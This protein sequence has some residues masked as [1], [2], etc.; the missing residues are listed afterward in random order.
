[1]IKIDERLRRL[2]RTFYE[3]G[4]QVYAVGG[5]V[6][7]QLA[8]LPVTDIDIAGTAT[9][10]SLSRI[11]TDTSA[12]GVIERNRALGT[13]E[14]HVYGAPQTLK[15]EYTAFRCDSYR[16]GEHTPTS[17]SFTRD[18]NKDALRRDFTVNAIYADLITGEITDPTAGI[19]DLKLR[20]L[21]TVCPSVFTEDG[22][23]IMRLFR[24]AS[25]LD[26]DIDDATLKSAKANAALLKDISKER[27]FEELRMILTSD[28]KYPLSPRRPLAF[29]LSRMADC[30]VY[31]Y[32]FNGAHVTDASIELCGRVESD[33]ALRFSALL[34]DSDDPRAVMT[35][36][37]APKQLIRDVANTV[38]AFRADLTD[39]VQIK[40]QLISVGKANAQRLIALTENADRSAERLKA[41][42]GFLA[43]CGIL[44]GI[45]GLKVTGDDCIN[46][47]LNG[48]ETGA[49]LEWL[50][51]RVIT[52]ETENDREALLKYLHQK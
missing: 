33:L 6:R 37:K 26:W 41:V 16:G 46:S 40:K 5:Y 23:R 18:I 47:G 9:Y 20:T 29:H 36:L 27:I 12:Y 30:G 49:M 10:E 17:V 34:S 13:V 4:E 50:L 52:G 42:Y 22:L 19:Q 28:T 7:N 48:K 1:M 44:N 21:R 39:D 31:E 24:F 38:T 45:S 25:Q 43:E 3:A 51:N 14:I 2:G 8:D 11:L 15:C 35:G 32:I